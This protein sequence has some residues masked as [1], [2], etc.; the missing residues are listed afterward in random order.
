V[1]ASRDK[2]ARPLLGPAAGAQA[3][4]TG[5]ARFIHLG[6]NVERGLIFP[7]FQQSEF[8]RV[9]DA[10]KDLELFAAGLFHDFNA[11]SLEHLGEFIPLAGGCVDGDD[12]ADGHLFFSHGCRLGVG[13]VGGDASSGGCRLA[14][15]YQAHHNHHR[16]TL[17]AGFCC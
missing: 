9:E 17:H 3:R 11:A 14:L 12:E 13:A 8:V 5:G 15:R 6:V 16:P 7:Q 1:P 2:R 4:V 10:L